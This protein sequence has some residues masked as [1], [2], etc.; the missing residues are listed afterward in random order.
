MLDHSVISI[1]PYL[2]TF[3]CYL[4]VILP[5]L[6]IW[7]PELIQWR[8]PRRGA[9]RA[10]DVQKALLDGPTKAP[11]CPACEAERPRQGTNIENRHPG[12][13]SSEVGPARWTPAI[14]T[15]LTRTAATTVG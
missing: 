10:S 15:A 12:S 4:I 13:N 5:L 3:C 2:L 11:S 8:S 9:L 1:L 7:L 14:I 6:L